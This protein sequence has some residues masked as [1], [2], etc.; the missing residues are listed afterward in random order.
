MRNKKGWSAYLF[1]VDEEE[2]GMALPV[3]RRKRK[4]WSYLFVVDEEEEGMVCFELC[5]E[6]WAG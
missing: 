5:M 1:V 3:C 6:E 2:E 4:G